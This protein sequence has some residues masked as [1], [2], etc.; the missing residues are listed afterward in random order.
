MVIGGG[1][2]IS[3]GGGGSSKKPTKT[4]AQIEADERA[5]AALLDTEKRRDQVIAS[6]APG[7]SSVLD[8]INQANTFTPG[9][10]ASLAPPPPPPPPPDPGPSQAQIEQA[11]REQAAREQ[12][13]R[14]QAAAEQAAREQAAREQAA[15]EQAAREQA[16]R[17][18]AA[19]EQAAREQAAR[20]EAARIAEAAR[21]DAIARQPK[22][23]VI[24]PREAVKY[25]TPSDVLIDTNDL[26]VDLILKLTLEKIGGIELISLVRHDTVNGQNIVYRP[27]KNVSQLAISYNPQNMV[28]VPDTAESFFKNFPIRLENYI[29]QDTNEFPPI[30]AYIDPTTENVI[31]DVVNTKSDYEIEV[32]M[33]SSG[34][35][36]NDT[37]YTEDN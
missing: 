4:K 37:I 30:T 10:P 7:P 17:E 32:Q 11:A 12:A 3:D 15:R 16:A 29:L 27:V 14:D 28:E 24:A 19:R 13:A 26:P 25:A 18:Q 23:L 34:Q 22:P 33:V 6:R 36:F 5:R 9:V 20:E 31:I 1:K 35:V 8:F 21:L 2:M